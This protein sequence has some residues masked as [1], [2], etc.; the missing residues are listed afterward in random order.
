[1]SFNN[2]LQEKQKRL[3]YINGKFINHKDNLGD[4]VRGL[5]NKVKNYIFERTAE[6][7]NDYFKN[8]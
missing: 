2:N 4:T 8:S 6:E 7:A 1:M 3:V 5:F